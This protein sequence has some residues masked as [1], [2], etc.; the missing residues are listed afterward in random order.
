VCR[1][2]EVTAIQIQGVNCAVVV[3]LLEL[4]VKGENKRAE[5]RKD[6]TRGRKKNEKERKRKKNVNKLMKKQKY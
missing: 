2:G 4:L 3:Y 1:L 6:R 5:K